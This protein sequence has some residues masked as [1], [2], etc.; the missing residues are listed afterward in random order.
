MARTTCNC[1]ETLT[2]HL[3]PNDIQLVVYTRKEWEEICKCGSIEVWMIPFPKY[4]VWRCPVCKRI[5]VYDWSNPVPLLEYELEGMDNHSEEE[6]E[7]CHK[8]TMT[9]IV[10]KCGTELMEKQDT[11]DIELLVY[12]DIEWENEIC[13]GDIVEPSKIRPPHYSVWR[14][15]KCERIMVYEGETLIKVYVLEKSRILP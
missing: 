8:A 12:T 1:G 13:T 14:C 3:A 10:C 11:D 15:P 7:D 4:D 6:A 9:Q 2:N 5:A